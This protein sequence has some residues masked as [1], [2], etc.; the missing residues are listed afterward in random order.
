MSDIH[1][2]KPRI[3]GIRGH[4]WPSVTHKLR[5][6]LAAAV[7][8]PVL[9]ACSAGSPGGRPAVAPEIRQAAIEEM[10]PTLECVFFFNNRGQDDKATEGIDTAVTIG[11]QKG[12]SINQIMS[13]YR[14]VKTEVED[15]VLE[16][17]IV[18]AAERP[19]RLPR[20]G[21]DA[22]RPLA[23]D[24]TEAWGELYEE[25]CADS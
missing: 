18:I 20:I 13:S 19:T 14:V 7:S 1:M 4:I 8:V 21:G 12:L 11:E 2:V 10:R 16:K 17:A 24:E 25:Q 6:A 15:T 22:P 3:T 5:A 23:V 9:I